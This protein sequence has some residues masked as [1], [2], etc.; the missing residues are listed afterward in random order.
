MGVNILSGYSYIVG[1]RLRAHYTDG[2][3]WSYIRCPVLRRGYHRGN[4]E[5]SGEK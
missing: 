1:V 2:P 4:C 5:G 3:E